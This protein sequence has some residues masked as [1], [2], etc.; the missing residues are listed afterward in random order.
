MNQ[1]TAAIA[2]VCLVHA[3]MMRTIEGLDRNCRQVPKEV[4]VSACGVARW[5]GEQLDTNAQLIPSSAHPQPDAIRSV[6]S[7]PIR[8][9]QCG[10]SRC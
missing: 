8:A 9:L 3:A 6:E 4:C 5:D 2:N 10:A 1:T 7:S